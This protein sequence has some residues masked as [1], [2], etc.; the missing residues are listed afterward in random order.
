MH[1]E[2]IEILSM[3]RFAI[4]SKLLNLELDIPEKT[5]TRYAD[6]SGV[7]IHLKK[8]GV[9]RGSFGSTLSNL[10]LWKSVIC[11]AK[12]A[13]FNDSRF[14]PLSAGEL[15]DVKLEVSILSEPI[16]LNSQ[17]SEYH[18]NFEYERH[19]LML[20]SVHGNAILLPQESAEFA[21]SNEAALA[22]LCRKAG[23]NSNSWRNASVR[24]SRFDVERHS[25]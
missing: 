24:I 17:P 10:P 21:G 20:Q 13:A 11:A 3:A 6:I 7:Y 5:K 15:K 2:E 12:G 19:G 14:I 1:K 25:E 16:A 18:L 23:L 22:L 9:L 8:D 4:A